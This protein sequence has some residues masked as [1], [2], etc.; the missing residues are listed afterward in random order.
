MDL[1][2][3]AM[4]AIAQGAGQRDHVQTELMLRQSQRG[5]RPSRLMVSPTARNAGSSGAPEPAPA[6]TRPPGGCCSGSA[7]SGQIP[8]MRYEPEPGFARPPVSAG[9][10]TSPDPC[11]IPPDSFN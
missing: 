7:S 2:D 6:A 4:L 8:D 11:S 3:A 1:R 9:T 5:F 10:R